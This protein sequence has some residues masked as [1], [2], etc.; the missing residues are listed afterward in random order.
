MNTK[1]NATALELSYFQ[2]SLLSFLREMHPD[3]STDL[4]FIVGRGDTAAMSYS[5][6][7]KVG[8]THDQAEEISSQV[9]YNGLHFSPY[10]TLVTILWEEFSEEID[11][12]KAQDLAIILLPHLS[13]ILEKYTLSD[14]FADTPYYDQLYTELTGAIQI[15]LEDGIQ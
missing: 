3:K 12:N 10:R 14:D 5:D 1:P 8:Q 2:L 13:G 11:P 6:A 4:D 7:I 15:L 9:L